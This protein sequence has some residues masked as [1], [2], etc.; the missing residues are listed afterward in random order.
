[1]SSACH[2][3][4]GDGPG[5]ADVAL[6]SALAAAETRCVTTSE[7]L[8]PPRRR[9]LE[10]LLKADGPRKAYDLIADFGASGEPA[11]PPTVYRALEFLERLG[12]AHRIE[13][14]NA[15]VPCRLDTAEHR[16]AFLLCE[17]CGAAEEFEPDFAVQI[18]AAAARGYEV[19][20]LNLE[21]RGLCASCR[22]E[23]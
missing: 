12:F 18:A 14:M 6:A 22:A 21:A 9:V 11:K 20:A 3:H 13:S 10:L 19:R 8:T 15:Y 17:C 4:E 5:L 7:R 1:M 16:A 2:H 23:A